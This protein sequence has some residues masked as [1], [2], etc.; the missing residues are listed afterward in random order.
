[1][2]S[3]V[4]Y[5]PQYS[6]DIIRIHSSMIYSDIIEYNTLGDTKTTILRCTPINSKVK[7][8]D[9]YST[10][11]YLNDHSFTSLH[12]KKAVKNYFHSIKI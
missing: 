6:S 3:K 2:K 8:K 9:I 1:M 7:R 10:G 11:L 5:Y 4:P 12:F